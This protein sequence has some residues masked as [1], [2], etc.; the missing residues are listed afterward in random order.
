MRYARWSSRR[1]SWVRERTP[2]FAYALERCASTV[3]GVRTILSSRGLDLGRSM[4]ALGRHDE[5]ECWAQLGRK[6]GDTQ[7]IHQQEGLAR[8]AAP[9]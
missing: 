9:P 3:F 6:L 7:D 5:A 2:S 1:A 8:R 4:C